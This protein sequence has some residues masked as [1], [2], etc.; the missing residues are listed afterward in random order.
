MSTHDMWN[1]FASES[2]M[3]QVSSQTAALRRVIRARV[4]MVAVTPNRSLVAF[5][6]VSILEGQVDTVVTTAMKRPT[7]VTTFLVVQVKTQAR[8]S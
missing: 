4:A 8:A 1:V 6:F 5:Q 7:N 2:Q 3:I